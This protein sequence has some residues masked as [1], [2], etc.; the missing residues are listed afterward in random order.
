MEKL[1]IVIDG[2]YNKLDKDLQLV[3]K[4]RD[5]DDHSYD[6]IAVITEMPIGTVRSKL[7]RAR[8]ILKK[9]LKKHIDNE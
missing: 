3:I 6:E 1:A 9:E 7:H 5:I 8:E 2:I 4:L